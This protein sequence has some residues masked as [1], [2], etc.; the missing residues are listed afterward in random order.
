MAIVLK[1]NYLIELADLLGLEFLKLK[2]KVIL[3]VLYQ[4]KIF[5]IIR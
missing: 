5:I 3:V 2:K 4:K 1:S